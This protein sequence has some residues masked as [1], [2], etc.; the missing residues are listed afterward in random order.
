MIVP[1]IETPALDWLAAAAA[2]RVRTGLE[3]RLTPRPPTSGLLDLASNDYL[4]LSTDPRVRA[5]AVDAVRLWGTGSTGSRLVTGSTELHHELERALAGLVG[6]PRAVVFS[7]GYLANL[8]MITAL[9]GPDCLVIC[10]RANHASLIDGCRLAR[11][12]APGS[13]ARRPRPRR[14]H[15]VD[16][17][18]GAGAGGDRRDR[19]RRR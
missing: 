17:V 9:A 15:G 4:G 11:S 13:P 12:P 18:R 10:D 3:R 16:P 2:E 1:T 14:D 6:A 19:L 8:G 5:A 7:S